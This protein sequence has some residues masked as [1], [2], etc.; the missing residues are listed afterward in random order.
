[1]GIKWIKAY[2]YSMGK[3]NCERVEDT[4]RFPVKW[5]SLTCVLHSALLCVVNTQGAHILMKMCI[6]VDHGF[7]GSHHLCSPVKWL[8]FDLVLCSAP[9]WLSGRVSVSL[10]TL[11]SNSLPDDLTM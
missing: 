1:M 8:C 11:L 3:W 10:A 5:L 2:G 6:C 4:F 7:E 9:L